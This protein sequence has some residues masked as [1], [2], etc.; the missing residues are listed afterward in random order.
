MMWLCVT[1]EVAIVQSQQTLFDNVGLV[2]VATLGEPLG[3]YLEISPG[4][5]HSDVSW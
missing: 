3:N 1:L 4:F 2:K 5:P